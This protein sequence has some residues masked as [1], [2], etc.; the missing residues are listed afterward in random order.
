M[1]KLPI[2]LGIVLPLIILA[3]LTP[4]SAEIDLWASHAYFKEGQFMSNRFLD[5]LYYYALVP[6]WI[7]SIGGLIVWVLSYY[8]PKFKPYRTVGIYLTLTLAIGSGVFVHALFKEQWGRPRPKESI[9]FGGDQPFRPYYVPNFFDRVRPYKSF[10]CG[11][12]T[13]GFYF[14]CVMWLGY[15]YKKRWL[16]WTGLGLALGFGFL[17]SWLRIAQGGHFFTDA[18]V[19]AIVMWLTA[20]L[21][22]LYLFKPKTEID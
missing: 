15:D 10:A 21:L 6:A 17:L 18:L 20:L 3:I 8:M 7:V 5:W 2:G 19:S 11:H 9:E 12:C 1:E 16:F 13:M 14:F 22:Y 4:W